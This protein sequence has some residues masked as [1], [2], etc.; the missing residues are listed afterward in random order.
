M[1]PPRS[2]TDR[3]RSNRGDL[4]T[5]KRDVGGLVDALRGIEDAPAANDEVMRARRAARA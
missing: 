1:T 4:D 2:S 5:V 3:I